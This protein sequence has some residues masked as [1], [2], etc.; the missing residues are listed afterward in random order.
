MLICEDDC[1]KISR[2]PSNNY[3]GTKWER[4]PGSDYDQVASYGDWSNVDAPQGPWDIDDLDGGN[5]RGPMPRR[6]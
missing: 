1:G 3:T 5:R 6:R 2:Y 4:V